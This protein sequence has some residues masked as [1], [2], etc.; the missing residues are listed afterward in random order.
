MKR[1]RNLLSQFV[2]MSTSVQ[3]R[4]QTTQC[5]C[6]QFA[7]C[8]CLISI[9]SNALTGLWASVQCTLI[10]SSSVYSGKR[11]EPQASMKT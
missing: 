11:N 8:N 2:R 3:C 5:L 7:L 1:K 6:D 10:Q 9:I 4:V